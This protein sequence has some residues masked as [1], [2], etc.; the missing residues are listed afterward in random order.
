MKKTKRSRRPR[1]RARRTIASKERAATRCLAPA[2]RSSGPRAPRR[3]LRSA[4]SAAARPAAAASR[5]RAARDALR[6]P[7]CARERAGE[8]RDLMSLFECAICLDVM[9]SPVTLACGASFCA[10]CLGEHRRKTA[11]ARCP[12]CRAPLPQALPRTSTAL[13]LA[14]ATLLTDEAADA[15]RR[16]RRDVQVG[17][18]ALAGTGVRGASGDGRRRR[19]AAPAGRTDSGAPTLAASDAPRGCVFARS[20]DGSRSSDR[21]DPGLYAAAPPGARD[22][23]SGDGSGDGSHSSDRSDPRR[24]AAAPR[25][26]RHTSADARTARGRRNDGASARA[27]GVRR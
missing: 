3:R 10:W 22:G 9:V 26:T 16:G 8:A 13:E 18:L 12:H 5:A 14:I 23:A 11:A 4:A 15:T 2:K 24:H 19:R 21:T 17:A 25:T 7:P 1:P 27:V 6:E 20:S